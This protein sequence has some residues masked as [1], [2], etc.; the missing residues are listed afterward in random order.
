MIALQPPQQEPL[1]ISFEEQDQR[2]K[3]RSKRNGASPSKKDRIMQDECIIYGA[4][5][6]P[7][8]E[9]YVASYSDQKSVDEPINIQGT[10]RFHLNKPIGGD[11]SAFCNT[12]YIY[13]ELLVK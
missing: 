1:E 7:L 4:A 2:S 10:V 11:G 12:A 8:Q 3:S 13:D 5:S 6:Q 9:T